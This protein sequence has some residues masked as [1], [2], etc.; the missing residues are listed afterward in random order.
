MKEEEN[1]FLDIE[2]LGNGLFQIDNIITNQAGMD[3]INEQI[4]KECLG[5]NE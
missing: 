2:D 1:P 5:N 4:R 3:L